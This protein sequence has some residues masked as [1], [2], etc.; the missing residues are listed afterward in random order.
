MNSSKEINSFITKLNFT[1]QENKNISYKK[2]KPNIQ[3]V[4]FIPQF[5]KK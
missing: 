2:D 3:T 5:K 1:K 4:T